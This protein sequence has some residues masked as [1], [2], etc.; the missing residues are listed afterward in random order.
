M[1]IPTDNTRYD[2]S[3]SVPVFLILIY[4]RVCN[5]KYAQVK[6]FRKTKYY[7]SR[8]GKSTSDLEIYI[9]ICV[10]V[11]V[12]ERECVRARKTSLQST[13]NYSLFRR[14]SAKVYANLL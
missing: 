5:N 12:R 3:C 10:C 13:N 7:H 11:C 9:Y 4:H 2:S 6:K 1:W 8:K 14:V